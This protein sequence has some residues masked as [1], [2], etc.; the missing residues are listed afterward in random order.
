MRFVVYGAGAVGGVIGGRLTQSGHDV[1]LI[2]RGAHGDALRERGLL[3]ESPTGS[4][5]LAIPTVTHP[6]ELDWRG[7]DV[8]V[9]AMKSQDTA[10]AARALARATMPELPDLPVIS[11]QN[12]VSNEP[13]LLRWF[14]RVYGMC[15]M[16]PATHLDPG[17]VQA[18]CAPVSGLLD[19]GGFPGGVDDLAEEVAAALEQSTFRSVVRPDIMRWKR[20]KLVMNLGNA[21]QALCGAGGGSDTTDDLHA[22]LGMLE[23]EA[24]SVFAAAR[25]DVLPAAEDDAR[26]GDLLQRQPIDGKPRGGGSTWQSF[27][28]G[29]GSVET[30]HLNGEIVLLGRLHGMPTPANAVVQRL[31]NEA[32]RDRRPPGSMT[33]AELLRALQPRG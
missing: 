6:D 30:D 32:A 16:C 31:A 15:V 21:V 23:A 7:G 20:R 18:S 1:V 28:R 29:T 26:R 33:P 27:R 24:D 3:L 25:I 19:L 2:A 9:L 22:I 4:E 8:A 5:T 10:A 11:A 14:D 13:E 17:V 12:G